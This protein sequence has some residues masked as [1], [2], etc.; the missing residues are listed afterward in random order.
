MIG[1]YDQMVKILKTYL[2]HLLH[3]EKV[4]EKKSLSYEILMCCGI[5]RK[6]WKDVG[7]LNKVAK[8]VSVITMPL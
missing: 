6:C 1:R 3:Q 7:V 2:I 8:H 5:K 4:T